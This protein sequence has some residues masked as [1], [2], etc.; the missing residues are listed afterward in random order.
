MPEGLDQ[1]REAF[2]QEVAPASRPRDQSGRFVS[3]SRA[4]EPMF[5]PRPV[6]GDERGD[7]RDGGADPRYVEHER[8]V[9]DG[10][11]SEGYEDGAAASREGRAGR[12]SLRPGET[13]GRRSRAPDDGHDGA[14]EEFERF[15]TGEADAA[16]DDAQEQDEGAGSE[17]DVRED[18][19]PRYQVEIDGKPVEVSLNEALKGYV[20]E[21][22]FQARV[23]RISQVAQQADAEMQKAAQVQA[24]YLTRLQQQEE[25]FQALLP[26][27]PNWDELFAKDPQGAHQLQKNFQTIYGKL[28]ALK[29]KR[30][31]AAQQ[32][33][34]QHEQRTAEYAKNEFAQFIVENRIPDEGALKKEL[35]S[36]R[37]TAMNAGFSEAEVASVYDRRMLTILRKA[38][39]YDRMMA[40]RP[41]PVVPGK[42]KTLTPGGR[43]NGPIGNGAR[44]GFDDAMRNLEKTGRMDD[45]TEVFRRMIRS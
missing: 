15:D 45:A 5:Q 22:D 41:L 31:E 42:G 37:Q 2:A 1:A 32:W 24:A 20:R 43:P 8:R 29:A 44:R 28:N 9:A 10:R 36:M 13:E 18:D 19:G 16:G 14:E 23:Q 11:A 35:S 12:Q 30:A 17:G 6:E 3:T 38:S 27:E 25:E 26:P 39:K 34:A 33:Q 40:N 4:P 21:Q 7:T